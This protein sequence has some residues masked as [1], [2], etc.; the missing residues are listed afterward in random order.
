[1]YVKFKDGNQ[2]SYPVWENVILVE[3]PTPEEAEEKAIRRAKDVEG[4]SSDSFAW[5]QRP[6]TWVFTGLRKLISVSHP[7]SDEKELDGAEVTF[8]E[9]EVTTEAELN[10]L[11]NGEDVKVLYCAD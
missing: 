7:D 8:S 9:F 1:M 6:A 2:D 3:A 11:V 4:D 5:N 10:S